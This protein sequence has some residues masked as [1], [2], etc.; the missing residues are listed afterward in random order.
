MILELLIP[1]LL[2]TLLVAVLYSC[3]GHGGASGYIAVLALFSVAPEVFKP[4]ALTLNLLVAGIATFSFARAGHFSWR[5]F[6]PFA[7]TSIPFSF[8][9]GYLTLP[10]HIY[11]PLVGV[12]LL[13]SAS[14]LL[15]QKNQGAVRTTPPATPT[16][17]FIGAALGLLSGLTGVGGGIFLSPLLLLFKWGEPRE[18]SAVA[19]LF[20]LVNSGAGLL[21]H[22]SGVQA[23]PG[24][25]P[26]LAG[27][28]VLGGVVGSLL[29]SRHLPVPTIMRV[30][31]LVLTIAGFKL[32]LV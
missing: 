24:Y 17:L 29:G 21:G 15:L 30:L 23:I 19:A 1:M 16:A 18:V 10:S 31:S 7:A 13:L 12:V 27:S 22:L 26:L 5:L 6:W 32:L 28:A 8:L 25:A 11:R 9:G 2:C 14:R 20:I 4:T 3:V